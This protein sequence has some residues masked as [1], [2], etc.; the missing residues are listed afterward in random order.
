[1]KKLILKCALLL[2]IVGTI[3]YLG[4]VA[5]KQ[6]NTYRNL[7]RTEE[8]EKYHKIPE[9][10]E[11]A[12]FGLSHGRDA[13]K[14][15]PEGRTFFNFSMSAQ[16]A[17]YDAALLRQYQG[18]IG[19]DALIILTFTYM[20]PYRTDTE[21]E[22]QRKQS[23]YYRILNPENI[24]DVDHSRYWLGRLSPLLLLDL[25]D[26]TA[27]FLESPPLIATVDERVGHDC[28]SLE[29]VPR[30]QAVIEQGQWKALIA[31]T[32]PEVNPAMWDAYRE[33]LELCRNR[34]WPAVLVTPPYLSVYN[35]C[36]PDGF[37][38]S[39][40]SRAAELS[41]TYNIP[42][43][44]YSHDPTFAERYDFYRD[45]QHMNLDGAAEFNNRFFS[46]VQGLGLLG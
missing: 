15:P 37:Y 36:F 31:A 26:I 33:M 8:T 5:Y 20:S 23:R 38:E 14:Y 2:F 17:Q 39:F 6:T 24:L 16:T 44:D 18:R 32:Y 28:F 3:L 40:L 21:D 1:M 30:A 11:I 13:F 25:E 46:D 42:Y 19:P 9:Q 45:I 10:I 41:E 27:A 12:V 43:L 34:G 4:G 35:D 22:F 7:E 29:N